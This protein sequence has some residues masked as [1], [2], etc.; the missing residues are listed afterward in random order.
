MK[1]VVG[2]LTKETEH[3]K[4]DQ[5]KCLDLLGEDQTSQE[6]LNTVLTRH[7]EKLN[8]MLGDS[9]QQANN[10]KQITYRLLIHFISLICKPKICLP[11]K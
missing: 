11:V 10:S 4:E 6:Q 9:K 5:V 2:E 1:K 7:L 8:Q 3:Y